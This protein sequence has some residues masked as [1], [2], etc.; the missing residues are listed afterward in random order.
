MSATPIANFP[1]DT[2]SPEITFELGKTPGRTLE[3]APFDGLRRPG[4][5]HYLLCRW[6]GAKVQGR[7]TSWCS[8]ACV[9]QYL[10]RTDPGFA[11]GK[12][13]QRD[14]GVCQMCRVDT[15]AVR[16][17]LALLAQHAPVKVM[18]FLAAKRVGLVSRVQRHRE[19][20][21]SL[22]FQIPRLWQMDHIVPV[23]KGGGSCGLDNLRTLCL[24]CHRKVTILLV[25]SLKRPRK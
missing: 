19:G 14:R 22:D 17:R 25:K 16:D 21:M 8:Q 6:C 11:A 24:W 15:L 10:I 5:A 4:E 23:V 3:R 1:A 18:V 12:V 13:F 9:D 2:L 20:G 7:R